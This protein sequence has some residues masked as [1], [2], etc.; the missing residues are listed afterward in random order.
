MRKAP[1]KYNPRLAITELA[2]E[3]LDERAE[4]GAGYESLEDYELEY[5]GDTLSIDYASVCEVLEVPL[6][7]SLGPVEYDL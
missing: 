1:A 3:I 6:P 5:I 2:D 4:R 7:E